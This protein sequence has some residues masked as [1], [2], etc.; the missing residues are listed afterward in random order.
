MGARRRPA[1]LSPPSFTPLV[2]A[3]VMRVVVLVACAAVDV[4][5]LSTRETGVEAHRDEDIGS[6]SVVAV[7]ATA[8]SGLGLDSRLVLS[9]MCVCGWSRRMSWAD[10]NNP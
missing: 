3:K 8:G 4:A 10:F 9:R 5:V 1:G 6:R 7:F 2:D